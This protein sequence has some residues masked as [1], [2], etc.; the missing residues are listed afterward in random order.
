[1]QGS[2]KPQSPELDNLRLRVAAFKPEYQVGPE[3]WP[4]RCCELALESLEQGNYGVGAVLVDRNGELLAEA[5][6]AVF[7]PRFDSSAHAEMRVLNQFEEN[8][9][10]YEDR[11]GLTLIASLE[12]CPMCC[13]RILAAGI[14]Q[15]IYLAEDKDGGMMSRCDKMPPAWVNISQLAEISKFKSNDELINLASDL[16]VAQL[17][18]LRKK[19]ISVIRP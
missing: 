14:G 19:L 8:Y 17:S 3:K 5:G 11:Q 4:F 9:P 13:S 18:F 7:A 6:N 10:A 16:A 1:M 15:I 12:P 2:T